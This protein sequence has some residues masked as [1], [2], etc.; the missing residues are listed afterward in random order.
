MRVLVTGG[1]GDL[2]RHVVS[3]LRAANI[4]VRVGARTPRTRGEVAYD[5]TD[6]DVT[7]RAVAD[8][9]AIVH[10]ASQ[11]TRRT[12][13]VEGMRILRSAAASAGVDHL[14]FVSIVGI[15]DHPFAYYRAK[16]TAEQIL[17]DG[18][19]PWT[20]ARA[21]QSTASWAASP[22]ASQSSGSFPCPVA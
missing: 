17:A 13:D 14:L 18:D 22:T 21:T 1:S 15:D 8:V 20:V 6:V 10:L 11:P 2:G 7:R 5:L 19:V 16:R 12:A 9:G 4:D 3:R